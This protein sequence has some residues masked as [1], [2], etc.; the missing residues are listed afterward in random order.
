MCR[1]GVLGWV[2]VVNGRGFLI[3]GNR[4]NNYFGHGLV[5]FDIG[6][7]RDDIGY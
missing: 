3:V 1:I 5:I 6:N 2:V 4:Y 7:L